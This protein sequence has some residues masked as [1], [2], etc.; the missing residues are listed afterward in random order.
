MRVVRGTVLE[1]DTLIPSSASL[2]FVKGGQR[3]LEEFTAKLKE[4]ERGCHL[5]REE[6]EV[7]PDA[8]D[9]A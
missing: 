4:L 1:G 6:K 7:A 2:L 8:V 3:S 5:F 9:S